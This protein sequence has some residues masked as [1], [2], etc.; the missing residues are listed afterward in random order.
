MQHPYLPTVQEALSFL[1]N[2]TTQP[3]KN[4]WI[5]PN[6]FPKAGLVAIPILVSEWSQL[7]TYPAPTY[8]SQPRWT[9]NGKVK[10][11]VDHNHLHQMAHC[12]LRGPIF[13]IDLFS[14]V[15]L[16][17]TTETRPGPSIRD[18]SNILKSCSHS[19]TL[20]SSQTWFSLDSTSSTSPNFYSAASPFYRISIPKSPP[21]PQYNY[22][23]E[24]S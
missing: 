6:T 22:H 5:W 3:Y 8:F 15:S 18:F 21:H 4:C 12:N 24:T 16:C 2:K 19:F 7:E 10:P 23:M 13:S 14:Q 20:F 1:N 11:T 9:V 17:L